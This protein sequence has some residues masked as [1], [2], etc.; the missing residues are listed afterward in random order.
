MVKFVRSWRP[1]LLAAL[2]LAMGMAALAAAPPFPVQWQGVKA[3][4][5]QG[6]GWTGVATLNGKIYVFGGL[7]G[8]QT[9]SSYTLN[10]TQIYDT[11][12]NTWSSGAA[13]PTARYLCTASVV[14]GKI[15][16]MG[17]RTIDSSGAGGPV[18][19]NEAYDPATNSWSTGKVTPNAIRGHMAAVWNGKI[20]IFGGN[21]GTY[22][23]TVS[24]YD[25]ATDNWS[26][27]TAMPNVRGY[28]QAVAVPSK[29]RIYVIGG[30]NG[31]SASTKY[32]GNAI[33]YDPVANAW[34]A[35]TISMV[36][37]E[38]TSNFGAA[39][40]DNGKVYIFPGSK[41]DSVKNTDTGYS[42]TIQVLDTATN[43]ISAASFFTPSPLVRNEAE[44][45][46][47][48]G[49]IY[50]IGGSSSYAAVDVLDPVAG[51]FYE[52]NAATPVYL[53]GC[54]VRPFGGKLWVIGGG[55]GNG[56]NANVYNYDAGANTWTKT[57]ATNPKPVGSAVNDL[58]GTKIA[59][60]DGYDSAGVSGAAQVFDPAAGTFAAMANDPTPTNAACGAVVG[61]TLYVFGGYNGSADV[62][63]GRA[64]N[65][66]ANTWST[67]ASLASAMEQ[68]AA[69]AYNGKIYIF[70]GMINSG[71][72]VN[73]NV[74]V[75]DPASDSFA[76][77]AT[78]PIGVYGATATVYKNYIIITGGNN[79]YDQGT[80]TYYRLAPFFQVYDPAADSFTSTS[81]MYSRSGHGL[82]VIGDTLYQ[83]TGDDGNNGGYLEDRLDIANLGT[84]PGQLTA[85]AS[86]N[87]T[88]GATPLTVQF[89]GSASGGTGPYTYSWSFGDDS[90]PSTE[91][92]PSHTFTVAGTFHV[93]LTVKDSTAATATAPVTITAGAASMTVT[94]SAD[95]TSGSKPLA[96]QFTGTVT[97][98][99]P[100]YTYLWIFGDGSTNST[101]QNPSHTF[102]TAGVYNVAF[103]AKDSTQATATGKVT[104]TVTDAP[105][106]VIASMKKAAAPTPFT[107]VVTG[108][109]LQQNIKVYIGTST[110]PWATVTWK[111]TSKIKIGGGKALKA[112]VPKGKTTALRFVNPD[113]GEALGSFSW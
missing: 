82:C 55:N 60:A 112:V 65:L 101:D 58:W 32:L 64:L 13:M 8:T 36:A 35:G 2:G 54:A 49:K 99:T 5:P 3:P 109:N 102:T 97:G 106:P 100:P 12:T 59:M 74:I 72:A 44:A 81:I 66:T 71:G 96:V 51:T 46:N 93:T 90:V 111:T 25:P 61:D 47:V 41:W 50:C 31:G 67:K 98:G 39:L 113:G 87:K 73:T 45:V 26:S 52:P 68:A 69:A 83:V 57:S 23:K 37:G 94:A 80:S 7:T 15:Y 105:P 88:S 108:S 22:Q 38:F 95:K 104:I 1:V 76:T 27:G 6:A 86:A 33:S 56:M 21:T 9:E 34:D 10:T 107:I 84:G 62:A 79:L 40:A 75:Y 103:T 20:Y 4:L 11:A 70:G 16:V 24:I 92:N 18:N 17:G 77:K 78:M 19:S 63:T 29:G 43:T 14:N 28:G 91:Q 53:G 110:T 85:S 30:D 48:G 89:T 42:G